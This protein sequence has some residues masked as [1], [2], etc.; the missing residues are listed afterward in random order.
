VIKEVGKALNNYRYKNRKHALEV[1]CIGIGSWKHTAGV[2][3]LDRTLKVSLSVILENE[4]STSSYSP[5]SFI[6]A[7]PMVG[8]IQS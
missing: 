6:E 8:E 2:E 5:Q 3:Q 4:I 1:P 7:I